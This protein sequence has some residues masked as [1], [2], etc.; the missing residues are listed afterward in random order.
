MAFWAYAGEFAVRIL[1]DS[2]GDA[3][4]DEILFALRRRNGGM[5][6][7]KSM[8]CWGDIGPRD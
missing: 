4:A 2:L 6:G 3:V 8:A 7:A 1:G 5:T